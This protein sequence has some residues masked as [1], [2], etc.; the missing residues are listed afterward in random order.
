MA[1]RWFREGMLPVPAEQVRLIL[2]KTTAASASASG[3]VVYA[4]VSSH[5]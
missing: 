1:D 2:V 5:D 3:V 4:R